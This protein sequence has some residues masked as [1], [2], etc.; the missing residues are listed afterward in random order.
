VREQ[1]ADLATRQH[2]VIAARQLV[3][4]GVGRSTIRSWVRSGHLHPLHRGVFAVG[5]RRLSDEALW[6][7]AV[8]ACPPG[9]ALDRQRLAALREAAPSRR[10]AAVVR[11]LLAEPAVP[12]EETRSRLEELILEIC[13][14]HPLPLPAVNVPLL[15]WE[16]DFLWERERFVVE[17]DGGDHMTPAQRDRDNERDAALGRAGYL[18]RRYGW[19]P[20]VERDALAREVASILT[21]RS[22]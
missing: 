20:V 10:G 4:L 18:V 14:D 9:S 16:V 7:A 17:A 5:H 8:L 22:G 11:E 3:E 6:L 15:G 12:L 1:I 21:E 2:G 13:R 19:R